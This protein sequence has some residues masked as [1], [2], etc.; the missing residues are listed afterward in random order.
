MSCAER[1]AVEALLRRRDLAPRM[2][3]RAEMV[4]APLLR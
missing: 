4:M 2:R 3:E 1:A